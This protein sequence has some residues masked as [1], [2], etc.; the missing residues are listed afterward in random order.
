MRD[1][2]TVVVRGL[3]WVMMGD[4]PSLLLKGQ[5]AETHNNNNRHTVLYSVFVNQRL[6]NA[7]RSKTWPDYVVGCRLPCV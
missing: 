7:N 2:K 5:S 6:T 4:I 1:N 3:G